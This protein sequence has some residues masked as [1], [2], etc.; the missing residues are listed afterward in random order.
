MDNFY[1]EF[2]YENEEV[3]FAFSNLFDYLKKKKSDPQIEDLDKDSNILNFFTPRELRYFSPLDDEWWQKYYS[4]SKNEQDEVI[5]NIPWDY[6]STIYTLGVGDYFLIDCRKCSNN[7]A[8][9]YFDPVGWPYGGTAPLEEILK[10]FRM[11]I[12]VVED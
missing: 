5:N 9:L 10:A 2:E 7:K 6:E 8:R 1:I 3:L 4:L 11:K 12:L